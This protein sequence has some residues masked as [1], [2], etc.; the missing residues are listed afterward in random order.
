[1]PTAWT[2]CGAPEVGE[3][4]AEPTVVVADLLEQTEQ[5][6]GPGGTSV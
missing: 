6:R 5:V 1:V 3:G 4:D 2:S